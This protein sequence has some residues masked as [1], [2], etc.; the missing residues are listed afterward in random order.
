MKFRLLLLNTKKK[1]D[2]NSR[3]P[4]LCRMMFLL[5]GR[6]NLRSFLAAISTQNYFLIARMLYFCDIRDKIAV[7]NILQQNV[8]NFDVGNGERG[9]KWRQNE[10]MEKEGGNGERMRKW[11]KREE[12]KRVNL[13]PF[14]LHFLLLYP[15]PL[16]FPILY[17]FPSNQDARMP[18]YVIVQPCLKI[19]SSS[20]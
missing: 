18:Q 5:T 20:L 13:S 6:H 17:P 11:R 4:P 15:F 9:R 3:T 7:F 19:F 12:M 1:F 10:E 2:P 14:P 16:H 8:T